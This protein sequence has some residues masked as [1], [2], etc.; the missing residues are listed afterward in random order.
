MITRRSGADLANMI[1]QAMDTVARR[2]WIGERF[3]ESKDFL[4]IARQMAELAEGRSH[5][6]LTLPELAELLNEQGWTGT[7]SPTEAAELLL[8]HADQAK[9]AECAVAG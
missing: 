2:I 8:K 3:D 4:E 9:P 5:A 6:R 1:Y 7:V